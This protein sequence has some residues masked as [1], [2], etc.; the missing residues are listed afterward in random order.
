MVIAELFCSFV[1]RKPCRQSC[2]L[3]IHSFCL[4][5]CFL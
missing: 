5:S 1:E 2:F 3:K 4:L